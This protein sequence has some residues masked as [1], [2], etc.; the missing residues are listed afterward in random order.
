MDTTENTLQLFT[1]EEFGYPI[2][3]ELSDFI[4]KHTTKNDR[5][6]VSR[7]T[8]VGTSILR[9]VVYRTRS[10]TQDNS[11]GIIELIKISVGRIESHVEEA[12]SIKEVKLIQEQISQAKSA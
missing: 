1:E 8:G 7:D 12:E 6:D 4:K 10:L 2:S 11:K 5:A 9:D 3:S